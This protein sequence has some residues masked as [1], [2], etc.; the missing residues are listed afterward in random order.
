MFKKL[1]SQA[2]LKFKINTQGPLYIKSGKQEDLNP[3]ATDG[4]YIE[5]YRNGHLEPFIPGTSLKG[6]FRCEAERFFKSIKGD[7]SICNVIN[8][9]YDLRSSDAYTLDGRQRYIKSCPV[10]RLFGSN[11]LKSRIVFSD[12]I[13][14]GDYHIGERTCVAIDRISGATK[15][16]AVFNMEYIEDASFDE[17]ITITNFEPYQIKLLMYLIEEMNCG[18]LTI[19]SMTSKGFGFVKCDELS[20]EVR[21][22]GDKCKDNPEYKFKDYYYYKTIVGIENI[23][24]LLKDKSVSF[25]KVKKGGDIDDSII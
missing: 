21:Y 5:T 1:E 20:L 7:Q 23:S 25:D 2:V 19:G 18:F 11:V 6:V 22:Y 10:C 15:G 8:R 24:N 16:G 17:T 4:R 12:G 14:N 13:V 3:S 9:Q